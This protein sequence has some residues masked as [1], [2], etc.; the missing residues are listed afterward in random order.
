MGGI[1][2]YFRLIIRDEKTFIEL[3]PA[4]ENGQMLTYDEVSK[5]LDNHKITSFDKV[6]L[7]KAIMSGKHCAVR[8]ADYA[9]LPEREEMLIKVSEDKMAV[10]VRFY[11]PSANGGLLELEDI[12][13]ELTLKG[14]KHGISSMMIE[15]FLADRKYCTT[16][17]VAKGTPAVDG[18][19]ANILYHFKTDKS[20]KPK[21]NEDGSVDFHSLDNI[22]SVVEGDVLA[23]L[24]PMDPGKPGMDVLGARIMPKKVKNRVLKHGNNIHVSEDGLN[25]ISDVKGHVELQGDRVFV[26][27]TYE[28]AD[29][30]N[31]T[32]GDIDYEGNVSVTGSVMSGFTVKAKGDV[33][34]GGVV[35]G[36]T[37]IAGGNIILARGIQGQKKG[38]LHAGGDIVTKFIE[39]A[40]VKAGG[41]IKTESIMYSEVA[42][43]GEVEVS[44]KKGNIVGGLTRA[45]SLIECKT[46][47][48]AMETKTELE[49]GID[50]ELGQDMVELEKDIA[51]L[52]IDLEKASQIVNLLK[53]KLEQK[54]VLSPD[55]IQLLKEAS[56][57]Y[58][59]NMIELNEKA[60]R[61]STIREQISNL[62]NGMIKVHSMAYRGVKL[63]IS[64]A[65]MYI[66]K[67]S[68]RVRYYKDSGEI[69]EGLL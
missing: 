42:A 47:G 28:V 25:L 54:E 36:A 41:N 7:N 34:V 8:V 51:A 52:Q 13:T 67:D 33:T 63:T 68:S 1:N 11:S 4:K 19:D 49:V 30:V 55:K 35:E 22:N 23:T 6:E 62:D 58:N 18:H 5:Y 12:I 44:G 64:N 48:S 10:N 57:S 37:I 3:V 2:A 27:N 45:G 15:K 31:T 50:P 43:K 20:L 14:I 53:K 60:T 65:V 17:T 38:M 61:F 46:L 59:K 66:R 21:M 39:S 69:R 9:I 32:T 26:S 24:E 56:D 29:N 40:T 16:Y